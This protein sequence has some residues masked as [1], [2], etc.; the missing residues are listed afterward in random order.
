MSILAGLI[1]KQRDAG[2]YNG[3][4]RFKLIR[5][6]KL[7]PEKH[8]LTWDE[9]ERIQQLKLTGFIEAARDMFLFS[10]YAHGMRFENCL[11]FEKSR[12]KEVISYR[13]NKGK[14]MREIVIGPHLLNIINRY[15]DKGKTQYLFPFL[16]KMPAD[17]WDWDYKKGGI[18]ASVNSRLK[19]VAIMAGIDKNI[20][21]HVARHTFA[22]LLRDHQ[23]S[24][25]KTDIYIIQK[26]LGHSDIKTTQMY[27][28]SLGDS[29][30]NEEVNAM[31]NSR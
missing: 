25:G 9:L 22:S 2:G 17:S 1:D 26:A 13:M 29:E 19:R 16:D 31:F 4:N 12:A 11:T 28:A 8:R 14:K 6:P 20:S 30:V 10:F 15:V 18:N 24:V 27:L 23:R 21:F 5:F 7:A 3:P